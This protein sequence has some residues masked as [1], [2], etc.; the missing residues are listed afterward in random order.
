MINLNEIIDGCRK[1]KRNAQKEL[2]DV[3]AP[4]LLGICIRYSKSTQE[5]EDILQ[6]GFI[7]ILTKIKDFKGDGS[8]EGWM[9]KVIVN[10][11]ISHFHKNKKFNEI[12]DIEHIRESDID[13][14]NFENNE[15][16][17]EE[18]LNI[19]NQMPEGYKVIFNLYAIEGFKHKEIAEMLNITESTSKSQYSRAKD[20]IRQEL[21]LISKIK[22]QNVSEQ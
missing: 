13:H 21:E 18:L 10:T 5:A 4:I 12:Q 14:D 2:Y 19:I 17:H 16:T 3:Y 9:K 11:A 7:K 22:I 8:F 20:K 15:F 6:E 1:N